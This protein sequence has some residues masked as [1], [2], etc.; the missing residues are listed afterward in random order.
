MK[1]SFKH[2]ITNKTLLCWQNHFHTQTCT[3][4]TNGQKKFGLQAFWIMHTKDIHGWVS[5]DSPSISIGTWST[6]QSTRST[7]YQHLFNILLMV[8][9]ASMECWSRT[10]QGYWSTLDTRYHMIHLFWL[11]KIVAFEIQLQVAYNPT[12]Y[13]YM[14]RNSLPVCILH[15]T[16]QNSLKNFI[17]NLNC[18]VIYVNFHTKKLWTNL[19]TKETALRN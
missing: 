14:F 6:S 13:N 2:Y 9:Q 18:F 11:P 17:S 5:I 8:S 12:P 15:W 16:Y 1:M 7:P 4:I 19:K 10:N 3:P